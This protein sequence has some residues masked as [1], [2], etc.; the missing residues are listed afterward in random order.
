MSLRWRLTRTFA[1]GSAVLAGTLALLFP[2]SA[3]S[4]AWKERTEIVWSKYSHTLIRQSFRVWDAHPELDLHFLWEPRGSVTP[5]PNNDLA[6]GIGTLSWHFSGGADYDR[7]TTY[8]VFKGQLK[9]GRPEGQGALMVFTTGLS[10]IGDWHDGLMNGR[11]VLRL[12]NGDKYDGEFLAGKMSGQGR[13]AATD[14]SVF[15]GSFR[16]GQKDGEG[17]LLRPDG[18]FHTVWRAGEEIQRQQLSDGAAKPWPGL[19]LAASTGDVQLKLSLDQEKNP[20]LND[21]AAAPDDN[22]GLPKDAEPNAATAPPSKTNANGEQNAPVDAGSHTYEADFSP[23]LMTIRPGYKA[24]IQAWKNNG[25]IAEGGVGFLSDEPSFA[26]IFMTAQVAN[27]S[28]AVSRITKAYL[29]V[30][31]SLTDP[32][33]YLE[34]RNYDACNSTAPYAPSFTFSNLGWGRVS[35][36]RMSYTLGNDRGHTPE[37]T[38]QL[39]EFDAGKQVTIADQLRKAKVDT[40]RL[41]KASDEQV[42][43]NKSATPKPLRYAFQC[44]LDGNSDGDDDKSQKKLNECIDGVVKSG[45][46]GDL[47]EYIAGNYNTISTTVSGHIEY[48]WNDIDGKPH[49]NNSP[50]TIVI[51][52]VSFDVE[53]GEGSCGEFYDDSSDAKPL[54]LSVD[55]RN[56]QIDLPKNWT[57]QVAPGASA[58]FSLTIAAPKTSQHKFQLIL[59]LADGSQVVSPAIDLLYFKPRIPK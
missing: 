59:E 33:P 37:A 10:Y 2:A 49:A 28:G 38:I 58:T 45:V 47:S 29:K 16:D 4:G 40:N 46:F 6:S 19:H 53:Q 15:I 18:S 54:M 23:G 24:M 27:N 22:S 5:D 43:Q 20:V 36:A 21:T 31:E 34:V 13:Y 39:G 48:Q 9:D 17:L 12:E 26:K 51:P 25:M 42:N 30:F 50:F 44:Q 57:A 32:E 55:R 11:G 52:L 41:K 3:A 8:S 7:K 14:G 56:Y 1:P 35:N